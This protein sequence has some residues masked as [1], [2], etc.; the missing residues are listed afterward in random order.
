MINE[1]DERLAKTK[2]NDQT[3]PAVRGVYKKGKVKVINLP[4]FL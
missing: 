2:I 4:I 3:L 1:V